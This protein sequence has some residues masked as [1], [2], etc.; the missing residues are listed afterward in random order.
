MKNRFE[1]IFRLFANH[2]LIKK[3]LN[4]GDNARQ[5]RVRRKHHIVQEHRDEAAIAVPGNVQVLHVV[6][7]VEKHVVDGVAG[8]ADDVQE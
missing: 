3:T 4:P 2:Y 5:Q 8:E 6:V 1:K 7:K